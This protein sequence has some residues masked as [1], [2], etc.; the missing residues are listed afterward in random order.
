VKAGK[1]LGFYVRYRG[2]IPPNIGEVGIYYP[3]PLTAYMGKVPAGKTAQ[4][5]EGDGE[6][7]RNL[8]SRPVCLQ[9]LR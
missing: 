6:Q 5:W 9:V 1:E 4:N 8:S 3:G 7:V 2:I